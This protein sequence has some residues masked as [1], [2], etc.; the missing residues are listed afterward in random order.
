MKKIVFLFC[1][2]VLFIP[3]T[4]HADETFE[5]SDSQLEFDYYEHGMDVRKVGLNPFTVTRTEG[6]RYNTFGA[7]CFDDE[8]FIYGYIN[9]E[10][11]D[12]YYDA[13]ILHLDLEGNILHE[14]IIDYGEQ[15]ESKFLYII[16]DIIM[17][18]VSQGVSGE[19]DIEHVQDFIITYDMNFN[20]ID[21][22]TLTEHIKRHKVENGLLIVDYDF[23]NPYEFAIDNQLKV[24]VDGDVLQVQDTYIGSASIAFF[25]QATLNGES[26]EHGVFIDYPGNYK[27]EYNGSVYTFTVEAEI[28]GVVDNETYNEPVSIQSSMGYLTLNNEPYSMGEEITKPGNYTFKVEG[29]NNYEKSISFT[30]VSN[31]DGVI[32]G[33]SYHNPLIITFDGEGYLNNNFVTSPLEVI[34]EGDYVLRIKGVNGYS[35]TYQFQIKAEENNVD[36]SG[37][38]QHVDIVI[39]VVVVVSGVIVLRKK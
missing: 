36:L 15:E 19:E 20:K 4:V 38:I 10:T 33:H 25:N 29:A 2:I 32:D 6:V 1:L 37:I 11:T 30:I 14:F 24:Y 5:C 23:K 16:D 18:H 12:S 3:K 17:V 7:L 39:I 28:S 13:Y 22:I 8:Y 26:V 21:E 9:V 31:L 27:L 35:E 34:D